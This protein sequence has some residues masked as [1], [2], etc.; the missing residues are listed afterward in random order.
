MGINPGA[1]ETG[2]GFDVRSLGISFH[3][4]YVIA[5]H[6]HPWG[7]LIYGTSGVMRVIAENVVW[8]VPPTRAVWLPP[9]RFHSITM[10]GEV[11]MRTLY[12]SPSR[13]G[14]LMDE[15]TALEVSPLL[16]EIILYIQQ[17]GML[18]QGN[19]QHNRLAG[20]LAD[21]LLK[22]PIGNLCLALP[23]DSRAASV[24][25]W[26]QQNPGEHSNLATIALRHGSSLRTMQRLFACE[27]GL[28]LDAWRQKSRLIHAVTRLTAGISVSETGLSCGYESTSAF[29]TA[30]KKQFGV[31]PGRYKA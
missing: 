22:A 25:N 28:S 11:D 2:D 9:R 24:A 30:F 3:D 4:G 21:L 12:L 31:T 8:F 5:R 20:L 18:E 17:L 6:D 29:I 19:Q 27:T 10:Q 1:I 7:Q 16:R 14:G 26:F 23:K 15:I 13:A